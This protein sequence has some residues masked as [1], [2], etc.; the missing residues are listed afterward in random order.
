MVTAVVE[1]GAARIRSFRIQL[2]VAAVSG[3]CTGP[4]CGKTIYPTES[5]HREGLALAAT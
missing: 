4:T 3:Y 2:R 1:T 5:T